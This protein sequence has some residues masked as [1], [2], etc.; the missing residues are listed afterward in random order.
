[1]HAI[2]PWF[3]IFWIA[4]KGKSRNL[5]TASL[6][7]GHRFQTLTHWEGSWCQID[8]ELEAV[9][10]CLSSKHPRIMKE[11]V[12]IYSTWWLFHYPRVCVWKWKKKG[13]D[14]GYVSFF[15]PLV[16]KTYDLCLIF[17]YIPLSSGCLEAPREIDEKF[18]TLAPRKCKQ[19]TPKIKMKRKI[20]EICKRMLFQFSFSVS[21]FGLLF[22]Y[23]LLPPGSRLGEIIL[24]SLDPGGVRKKES[25]V[26]ERNE[27]QE[28]LF[29]ISF[30]LHRPIP[31]FYYFTFNSLSI[32]SE[33]QLINR[34]SLS[35]RNGKRIRR[36]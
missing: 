23:L 8:Y 11:S 3:P 22:S 14:P 32:S 2:L 19:E 24:S 30:T 12:T 18:P 20:K 9:R 13:R 27:S 6:L 10:N 29:G 34:K 33:A 35:G 31:F 1:M 4:C 7:I 21:Y 26:S 28:T 16:I 15:L 36:M 5:L 17:F 25:V